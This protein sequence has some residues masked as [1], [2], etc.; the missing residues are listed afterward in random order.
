MNW[1]NIKMQIEDFKKELAIKED[2]LRKTIIIQ[3][4]L[5]GQIALLQDLIKKE[6]ATNKT[7]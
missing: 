2:L 7:A 1:R 5:E 3:Y 6:E 4:H